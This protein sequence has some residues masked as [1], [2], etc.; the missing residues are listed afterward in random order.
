MTVIENQHRDLHINLFISSTHASGVTRLS[1]PV[2]RNTQ[3]R[4]HGP[5]TLIPIAIPLLTPP[6][7]AA[8]AVSQDAWLS[9]SLGGHK[10]PPSFPVGVV[11][12]EPG[13]ESGHLP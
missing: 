8:A 1:K 6:P 13:E 9:T 12:E 10:V 3:L 5:G 4:R 11:P 2:G 7:P